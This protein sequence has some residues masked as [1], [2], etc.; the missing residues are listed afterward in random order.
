[1][2]LLRAVFGDLARLFVEDTSLAVGVLVWVGSITLFVKV[3]GGPRLLA[4]AALLAGSIAIL[5]WSVW[6]EWARRRRTNG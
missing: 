2:K 4:G 6:Q 1:V 3:F 5:L